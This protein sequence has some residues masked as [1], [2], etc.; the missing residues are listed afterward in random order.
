MT[1]WHFKGKEQHYYLMQKHDGLLYQRW[2]IKHL[3]ALLYCS[4]LHKTLYK[5]V[6]T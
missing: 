1:W 2:N 3:P 4:H 6:K 5:N